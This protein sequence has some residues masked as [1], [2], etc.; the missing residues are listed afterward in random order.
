MTR[1][2]RIRSTSIA[3]SSRTGDR[4]LSWSELGTRRRLELV[5]FSFAARR[6]TRRGLRTKQIRAIRVSR[7]SR[8]RFEK[9]FLAPNGAWRGEPAAPLGGATD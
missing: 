2:V 3:A 8:V 5:P 9:T 7:L 6:D 1:L 4:C